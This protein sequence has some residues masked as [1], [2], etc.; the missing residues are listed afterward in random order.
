[1]MRTT[2]TETLL[3]TSIFLLVLSFIPAGNG[4]QLLGQDRDVRT[5]AEPIYHLAFAD[6]GPLNSDIFI[7]DADGNNARP[8]VPH[9]ANDYNASFSRDGT[10]IVFTSERNGSADI[11]RVHPDGSGLEQLTDDPAYDDQ[12]ALSPDGR[13]L[14]FVSSRNGQADIYVLELATGKLRNITNNPAGDFRPA[15]SPDWKWIA[16]SSDRN[17]KNVRFNFS[18]QHSTEIYTMR[19]D[20][21]GVRRRTTDNAFAGSP[22]WSKD[23]NQLAIYETTIADVHLLAGPERRGKTQIA[24][25]NLR[26]NGKQEVSSDSSEKLSP[27]WLADGSI[28]Y[29]SRCKNCGI[30]HMNG[31]AGARGEFESPSWSPDGRFMVFHRETEHTWPPLHAV[32]TRDAQ[33]QLLRSGIFPSFSPSGKQLVCDD[34]RLGMRRNHI[35]LMNA[36]GTGRSIVFGDST[37]S[38]L[39]PAWSPR[40]DKVAFGLG[41]FFQMVQGPALAD[42]A[43]INIDGTGLRILTNGEGNYGFPSWSPDGK[44]IVCRAAT[45]S[46]KGLFIIEVESGKITQLTANTQDN[47]PSWSPDGGAIAFTSKSKR[48]NNYDIYTIKPDGTGL[49]RLTNSPGNDA[50]NV[51]SPDGKWI[52]FSSSLGGFNDEAVLHILNPQPYG[53]LTVMRADGSDVR[54]LTDNQFEDATPAWAPMNNEK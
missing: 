16:F 5:G 9:P 19:A 40:G 35:M 23:G 13:S 54:V 17:S 28:A 33:F 47:F 52:A 53:E 3:R 24:I 38:A 48:D 11:Y 45:D 34:Q 25:I 7:A 15:W 41:R 2:E 44:F 32:Y 42:I 1:M 51:W 26:D 12:A 14:A 31:K 39:A 49:K 29:A 37:R 21:S 22:S 46:V 30:E 6:L 43:V 4:Y 50:H 27:H 36:D 10:W 18:F 20:G 8:L